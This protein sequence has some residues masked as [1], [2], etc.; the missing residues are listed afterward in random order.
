MRLKSRWI[1]ARSR[2]RGRPSGQLRLP[3]PYGRYG[4]HLL[5]QHKQASHHGQQ[6]VLDGR[7]VEND[8]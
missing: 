4:E 1:Q 3:G 2:G 6:T 5:P 8:T 7:D